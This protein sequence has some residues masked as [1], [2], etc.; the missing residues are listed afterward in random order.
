MKIYFSKNNQNF[1]AC[2]SA[3]KYTS[4]AILYSKWTGEYPLSSHK[5]KIAAASVATEIWQ[6]QECYILE[7][8]KKHPTSGVW[9]TPIENI[10]GLDFCVSEVVIIWMKTGILNF[11]DIPFPQKL[12][13]VRLSLKKGKSE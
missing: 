9:Y 1:Y 7:N 2:I 10:S 4:E 3:P 13:A 6:Q 5:K 8:R 12:R 11:E